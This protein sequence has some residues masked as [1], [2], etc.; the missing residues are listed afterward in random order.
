MIAMG[1]A[2]MTGDLST[3]GFWAGDLSRAADDRLSWKEALG[4]NE[5]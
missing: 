1:I 3:F 2:M 5:S 4:L